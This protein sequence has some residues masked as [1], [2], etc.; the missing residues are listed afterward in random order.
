[1][2]FWSEQRGWFVQ[3]RNKKTDEGRSPQVG[4]G[5]K[6]VRKSQVQSALSNFNWNR[7]IQWIGAS[8]EVYFRYTWGR[9]EGWPA[10]QTRRTEH[11]KLSDVTEFVCITAWKVCILAYTRALATHTHIIYSSIWYYIIVLY[12][13]LKKNSFLS[14]FCFIVLK[15][16]IPLH[17]DVLK[18]I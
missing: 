16:K 10:G 11:N 6:W 17:T 3:V 5:G 7:R 2:C 15:S 9:N 13:Y 18:K 14:V 1:M 8:P 4:Q 12:M